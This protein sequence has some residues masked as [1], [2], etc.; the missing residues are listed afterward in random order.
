M[1]FHGG[2]LLKG[3]MCVACC[4]AVSAGA[5]PADGQEIASQSTGNA[6]EALVLTIDGIIEV[7]PTERFRA[8]AEENGETYRVRLNSPG[9]NLI[10]GLRLGRFFREQEYETEVGRIVAGPGDLVREEAPG[11]CASACALAFLGGKRRDPDSA[12]FLGFHQFF[13]GSSFYDGYAVSNDE[14][15]AEGISQAQVVSGLIVS[16]MVEMGI[17]ARV[18]A[19]SS[20]AGPDELIYLTREEAIEFNVVTPEGFGARFL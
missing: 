10:E 6:V 8:V 16:Y 3:F 19:A 13:Y 1:Q 4:L 20:M 17:D 14:A 5:L 9:G 2:V 11:S 7:G 18:F 15:H 12:G